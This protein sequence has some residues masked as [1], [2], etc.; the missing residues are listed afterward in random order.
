MWGNTLSSFTTERLINCKEHKQTTRGQKKVNLNI[1]FKNVSKI[2]IL[3]LTVSYFPKLFF[4]KIYN[5]V[6]NKLI[7]SLY[8]L[9]RIIKL[10][11]Q[12]I[13]LT[14]IFFL[15]CDLK[16]K[17]CFT[18]FSAVPVLEFN[19]D[20]FVLRSTILGAFIFSAWNFLK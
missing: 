8:H 5:M 10:W 4:S 16:L 3:F 7:D 17:L 6:D 14:I 11:K 2:N 9:T 19:V 18:C 12:T 13:L 20:N 15:R 1:C